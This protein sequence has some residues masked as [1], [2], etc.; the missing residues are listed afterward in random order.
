[1]KFPRRE[2][3][4][5]FFASSFGVYRGGRP[6]FS[7]ELCC[8]SGSRYGIIVVILSRKC[9]WS[10]KIR[11]TLLF[12]YHI[13]SIVRRKYSSTFHHCKQPPKLHS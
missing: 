6:C 13:H 11:W 12:Q 4:C 10:L 1:M 3:Q 5:L 2:E 7:I 9:V 8:K